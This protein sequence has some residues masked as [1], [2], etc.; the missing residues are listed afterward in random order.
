M[1]RPAAL[2]LALACLGGVAAAMADDEPAWKEMAVAP[3]GSFST[4]E[5]QHFTVSSGSSLVYG[6]D[7][8]TLAVG[9]DGV[10]RYVMVAR[11]PSGALNALYEGIRCG[12]AETKTYAR[13]D[14][15]RS[16]WHTPTNAEWRPLSFSGMTRPAMILAKEGL[17]NGKAVNGTPRE[18]LASLK[19]GMYLQR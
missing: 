4:T 19:N 10:I 5:L 2:L 17:C 9:E 18:M 12:S 11:S 3:P 1:N 7:P 15:N 13:W 16:A 14:N 8:Q 6:I